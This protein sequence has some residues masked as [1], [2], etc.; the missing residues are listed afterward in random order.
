MRTAA[1]IALV[2][3]L[4]SIGCVAVVALVAGGGYLLHSAVPSIDMGSAVVVTT[5]LFCSFALLAFQVINAV[6]EQLLLQR[7]SV[8]LDEEDL[9]SDFDDEPELDPEELANRVAEIVCDRLDVGRSPRGYRH[10]R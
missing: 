2:L 3:A 9:D 4:L 8:D 10:S 1:L 7:P 5:L 6:N